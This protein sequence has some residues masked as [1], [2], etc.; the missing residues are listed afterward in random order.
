MSAQG[1][2]ERMINVHFYYYYLALGMLFSSG[3]LPPSS[4]TESYQSRCFGEHGGSSGSDSNTF[5]HVS[6]P[7]VTESA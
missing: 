7:V 2:D 4:V 1:V 5:G 6:W 3:Y